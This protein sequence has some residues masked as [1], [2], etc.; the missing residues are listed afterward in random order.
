MRVTRSVQES[1]GPFAERTRAADASGLQAPHRTPGG[2][3]ADRYRCD[4]AQGND[5]DTLDRDA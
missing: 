4:N 5:G 3:A 2:G 1:G